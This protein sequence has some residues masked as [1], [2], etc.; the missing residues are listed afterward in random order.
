[1]ETRDITVLLT[2]HEENRALRERLAHLLSQLMQKF[3]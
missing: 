2:L 3:P 1:M